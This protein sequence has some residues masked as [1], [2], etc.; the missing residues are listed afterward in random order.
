MPE[1]GLKSDITFS[2]DLSLGALSSTTSIGRRF[3]LVE[4][5]FKFSANVTET[6]TITRDSK[7]G[8]NYDVILQKITIVD[9]SSYIYAP[10]DGILFQDDDEIK[11]QCTNSGLAGICYGIIKAKEVLQ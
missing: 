8:A 5:S 9:E 4:I 2:Q 11:V 10:R 7:Q 6:I 3:K 1:T